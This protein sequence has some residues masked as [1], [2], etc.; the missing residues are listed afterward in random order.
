MGVGCRVQAGDVVKII[1]QK[2]QR[3]RPKAGDRRTTEKNGLEIRVQAMARNQRGEPIGRMV[4]NGRPMF[5]W[6]KP[7]N[8]EKW[9]RYHLTA[10]ERAEL[11]F[12]NPKET[13]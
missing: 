8:L 12:D 2:P 10:A 4:S 6:C 7:R 11:G 1:I 9:D 13:P 5:D 3:P